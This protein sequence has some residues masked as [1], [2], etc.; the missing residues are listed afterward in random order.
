MARKVFV[1][2]LAEFDLQGQLAPRVI[3]WEDG[4]RFSVDRVLDIRRA[5]SLKV[6]GSG[7]R[8][9]C[10]I[11]GQPVYLFLDGNQWYMEGAD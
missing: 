4:R 9:T 7:I 1:K 3:Y 6:G 11:L 8:Y 5:A 2:V 10:R